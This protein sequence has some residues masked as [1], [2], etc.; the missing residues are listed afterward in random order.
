MSR[1]F[2]LD[3]EGKETESDQDEKI[4]MQGEIDMCVDTLIFHNNT[5]WIPKKMAGSMRHLRE[6]KGP[7]RRQ[8]KLL[9]P[10]VRL[11]NVTVFFIL[12]KSNRWAEMNRRC[13]QSGTK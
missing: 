4:S 8:K 1:I 10:I 5:V 3:F 13:V 9:A 6:G 11:F 2:E 7:G 12:G